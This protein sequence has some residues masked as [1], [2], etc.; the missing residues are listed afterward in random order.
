MMHSTI[1]EESDKNGC[2]TDQS[3]FYE[4]E[5]LEHEACKVST[6]KSAPTGHASMLI[7]KSTHITVGGCDGG[8]RW[9]RATVY[10]NIV[11][12]VRVRVRVIYRDVDSGFGSH[13]ARAEMQGG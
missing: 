10:S 8:R 13:C 11:T 12:R 3:D 4:N 6:S 2:E 1:R 5:M 9:E 7:S